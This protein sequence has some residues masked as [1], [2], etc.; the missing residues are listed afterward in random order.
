MVPNQDGAG[1]IV[2][3]GEGVDPGR[4]G[5]RV[6]LWEAAS[7]SERTAPPRSS[8]RCPKA[9]RFDSPTPRSFDLGAS[10]GIPAL[11]AHRCLTVAED[12]PESLGPGSARRPNGA[13]PG[14]SGRRRPRRDRARRVVGRHRH[15]H[16]EL[17]G[18]GDA[19]HR[20][21]RP[22][23]REL[24][25]GRRGRSDPA[26]R[27]RR[28]RPHRRGRPVANAALDTAVVAPSGT[29]ADLRDRSRGALHRRP[30]RHDRQHALPVRARLHGVRGG[31]RTGCARRPAAV[32]AGACASARM[33]G[34]RCIGSRSSGRRTP[35]PRW[36]HA[37]GKVLIDVGP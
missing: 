4:V 28:R 1:T 12:G 23:R 31:Q 7:G 25:S 2:A 29:I 26:G 33:R 35:T 9:R 14:R 13:R 21:R 37:V 27:A 30:H 22:P 10:L 20:R 11:T 3:V 36:S 34:C 5:E 19:R 32:A 24:P 17:Q 8:S 16:G 18:E 6:W 15:H